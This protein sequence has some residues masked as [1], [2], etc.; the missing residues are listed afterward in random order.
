MDLSILTENWTVLLPE[1]VLT[2]AVLVVMI[3]DILPGRSTSSSGVLSILSLV[4]IGLA[5]A[6]SVFVWTQPDAIYLGSATADSFAFGVRLVV[7]L[8]A[9]FGVLLSQNY[10]DRISKNIGEYYALIL[11]ATVG[12]MLMGSAIDLIIIFLALEIF[13]LAVYVLS[14]YYRENPRSTEAGMKYFL[15]GAFASSFFVYGMALIYGAG[16]TTNL[17]LLAESLQSPAA[18][19]M[20]LLPGIALLIVGFGF[21]VSLVPFHMWTPDVY[22]GAPTPVTAFMSVGTKT[23]AFAAFIRVLTEALPAQQETW[24]WM[25]AALAVITMTVGNLAALRQSSVKRM[26]AYSSVAHAGYLLVALVP[27]TAQGAGAALF[28]VFAYA[29]MNI[30]AFAVLIALEKATDGD[31]E[32]E[33]FNGIGSRLPWLALAMAIFMFSL[34]GIPPLAGFFGKFFIFKAAVDTGWAWLAVVGMINSAISAYYYLRVVV[35]MYF[36]EGGSVE[37]QQWLG[38]NVSVA[39]AAIGTV[40]VGLYPTFWTNLLM[41]LGG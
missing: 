28:Y 4:G 9:A 41:N 19:Q 13:S 11:L 3:V 5:L 39:V 34:A 35:A 23:A 17:R 15:L 36:N 1:M 12:M 37:R 24:G 16:G 20:L 32:Q 31:V 38:L 30:G 25:L 21:K 33:R 6:A 2:I 8:A 14:G 7:L 27:A 40:V 22:Q 26:L 29:F 10:I 18:N